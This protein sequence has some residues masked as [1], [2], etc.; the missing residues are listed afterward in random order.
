M[1]VTTDPTAEETDDRHARTASPRSACPSRGRRPRPAPVERFTSPPSVRAVE[2]TPERAA[3]VVRQSS[4]A[5]WVGFLGVVIVILFIAIYWFYELAPLG[6][7]EP[8]LDTEAAA[9]QVT[10]VERGYNLYEANCARC[11]GAN[12]EGGIGPALN[13][14]DKLFAHL[15]G[16]LPEQRPRWSAAATSAATRTRMMPVWSEQGHPPGPLNYIQIEDLIAFIRAPNTETYTIR[17]PELFEPEH[18]P[19]TGE[20]QTFTGWVD[21]NYKPAP[22]AT[23]F[24]ACWRTSSPRRPDRPRRRARPAEPSVAT[25][26]R[27]SS[28]SSRRASSSTT[29]DAD[30]PGRRPFVIEFDNQDPAIRTTSRSRTRRAR[31]FK[32]DV[33]PGVATRQYQ[34]PALA[35]GTYPFICTVHPTHDGDADRSMIDRRR[36]TGRRMRMEDDGAAGARSRHRSYRD[37]AGPVRAA[38]RRRLGAGRRSRRSSGW[39]SSSS[40]S[41]YLP[42]RAY[43]L[44]VGRTV[45]LGVLVWSPI[46]L[47]PPTNETLPCPAPVGALVPW[48]PSP[49]ELEPARSRGP[50]ARSSRSAPRSCTSAAST[51]RPPQSTVYVAKTVGTGNFDKWAE[52][53]PLPEPRADASV[54]YVAGSIYVIGGTRR[55]RRAD[56]HGLRPQPG[57]PD[58]RARRMGRRRTT[59]DAAR[60]RA[61]AAAIGGHAG[62]PAADRRAQRRR[63]RR[64]HLEDDAQRPGRARARGPTRRRSCR[65][66]PTRRPSSSATTCGCTAAATPTARSATVQRGEFGQRGRRGAAREPRR[67][68]GDPLGRQRRRRTCRRPAP[69]PPAGAPTARSTWPAATTAAARRPSSTGRSRPPTGDLP[70]WKHLAG[71]RPARAGL[72]GAPAVDHRTRTPSS[73]VARR[74]R[75]GPLASSLRANTAPQSPFFQ[76]GLVGATVPG[77]QDRGRD[78]PAARLPERRGRRHRELHHPDP[79]RLGVRP[80]GE[81]TRAIIG[82][83]FRRG[84]PRRVRLSRRRRSPSPGSTGPRR[85][86]RPA[87]SQA[88]I[89]PA[90]LT[91]SVRPARIRNPATAADRPPMWQTTSSGR[92]VGQLLD[93]GHERRRRDED[94]ARRADLGEFVRLADVEQ[95]R[96]GRVLAQ[97][98]LRLGDVDRRDRGLAGH[99]ALLRRIGRTEGRLVGV[100]GEVGQRRS[101][102]REQV[103]E[104]EPRHVDRPGRPSRPRRA[105]PGRPPGCGRSRPGCRGRRGRRRP[106]P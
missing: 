104:V 4:N 65:R 60:S 43:Y 58:R 57:P 95:D 5:R 1:A 71:Q 83:V 51:A 40:C 102:A 106:R 21:P 63:A 42:D 62:R 32:G 23:P 31:S 61:A 3:Q 92:S 75:H 85:T 94:G 13:R 88:S 41:G 12:G 69:T 9:Q 103:V 84:S 73:S 64:D 105:A 77:P 14:Q 52:G 28:S 37:E 56:R 76:L 99:G 100:R 79:D 90:T 2:L 74:G 68:Q 72:E 50:M 36:P 10:A 38:R 96:P 54:A 45:D 47:C 82:R 49:G 11:H 78:R 17:D 35:A 7:T 29:T 48:Q 39:S 20:V 66:R 19:I 16:R 98:A 22:G 89:P 80:Q 25:R 86:G 18:D 67:G 24:P 6:L 26:T 59:A 91:T 8:R 27:R 15:N 81:Q 30:R 44:T 46:N 55:G 33:F 34:V 101:I 87:R 93:A 53:P 97:P 70:E